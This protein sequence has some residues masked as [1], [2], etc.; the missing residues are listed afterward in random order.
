LPDY[1]FGESTTEGT[2]FKQLLIQNKKVLIIGGA[3]LIALF[4]LIFLIIWLTSGPSIPKN[5]ERYKHT[6]GWKMAFPKDWEIK[7]P[8]DNDVGFFAKKETEN[9]LFQ[10]GVGIKVVVVS[11]GTKLDAFLKEFRNKLSEKKASFF[12]DKATKYNGYSAQLLVYDVSGLLDDGSKTIFKVLQKIVLGKNQVFI[13][14]YTAEQDKFNKYK[15]QAT[16]AMN[17]LE[18]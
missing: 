13:Q 8:S 5:F 15:Q 11:T 9:D 1:N 16:D 3:A 12:E 6:T 7:Y 2:N 17:T 18:F 4:L 14:T 10:E